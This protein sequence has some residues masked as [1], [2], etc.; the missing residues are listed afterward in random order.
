MTMPR[1]HVTFSPNNQN[2][3]PFQNCTQ[4]NDLVNLI[5]TLEFTD[6][7]E[8]INL[9]DEISCELAQNPKYALL[10]GDYYEELLSCQD[11]LQEQFDSGSTKSQILGVVIFICVMAIIGLVLNT[12]R[13]R[14][15]LGTFE[16]EEQTQLE[17]E[18]SEECDLIKSNNN[19]SYG[20]ECFVELNPI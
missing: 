4:R 2:C 18:T 12:V 16:S 10:C 6:S 11:G 20:D 17:C 9:E 19:N 14:R 8:D 3:A 5:S 1:L 15:K 7:N 13:L